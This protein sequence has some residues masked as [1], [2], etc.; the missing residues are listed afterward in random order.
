MKRALAILLIVCMLL[1]LAACGGKTEPTTDPTTPSTPSTPTEPTTPGTT[2]PTA[3]PEP[4]ETA[5]VKD[6]ATGLYPSGKDHLTDEYLPLVQPGEDNVLNIGITVSTNVTSYE[7]NALTRWYE[8]QSGVKIEFTQFAGTSSDV[9][10]QISLMMASGE[11]LP[12]LL[13]RFSGISQT[14]SQEYGRDG[15]FVDLKPYY[16]NPE[17]THY[18]D[19]AWETIYGGTNM[20]QLCLARNTDP[21]SGGMYSFAKC[22]GDPDDMPK[23]HMA[24]N[25]DWLAKLGLKMPT[26]INELHDVLVAFRDKDPNGN[27]KADEI[28]MIARTNAAYVDVVSYLINAFVFYNYSYHFNVTDGK[29]W[30]PYNT[31]EYR[32][33]M[34]YIKSL[35]DE[36]LLSPMTWTLKA[37]E[38]KSLINPTDGVFTAGVVC[39]HNA[40]S[41]IE[42]NPSMWVYEAMPCLADET[43]KGG[44]GAK[45]AASMSFD[46]F[47]TADCKN[48]DLAFKFLDFQAGIEGYIHARWGEEGIDWDWTDGTTT[49]FLGGASRF[50]T[51]NPAIWNT[52]SNKLWYNLNCINSTSYF[53]KE[54]DMSDATNWTTARTVQTQALL[55]YIEEAG[56]PKEVFTYVVYTAEETEDR[57]D[58]T[59]D[60][61]SYISKSRT[62]FC[63]GI[64]D[65]TS[66]KDWN[67]YLENLKSLKYDHW[68]ELA[69]AAYDRLG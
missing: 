4:T 44:Y 45:T 6:P 7:D 42:N 37:A 67:E 36:G 16:D 62:N 60:L 55:K 15:Y 50:R 31:D 14:T 11:K 34:I 61:T 64:L 47:I 2:E 33:A 59:S 9:A 3:E 69:Q 28:P 22:E 21:V 56:Q 35:V 1:P 43:G 26:N 25:K 17:Y 10:T 12:D 29:I 19:D 48:P 65:P 52:P 46:T 13:W 68:V 5:I 23:S 40:V 8:E 38:L 63:T 20:K 57:A 49:G 32:K 58:F 18:Q 30:T 54:V 27:G 41:Y 53:N 51:Y 39:A 24:I 66:D